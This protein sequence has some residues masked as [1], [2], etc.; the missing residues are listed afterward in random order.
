MSQKLTSTE[1]TCITSIRNQQVN[2]RP[3]LS[4]YYHCTHI[5]LYEILGPER[6][7]EYFEEKAKKPIRKKG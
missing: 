4:S 1:T 5:D 6:Y 2:A 7:K 3:E